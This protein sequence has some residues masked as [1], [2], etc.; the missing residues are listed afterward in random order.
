MTEFKQ[1]LSNLAKEIEDMLENEKLSAIVSYQTD[2]AQIMIEIHW[3]DW[4]HEHKRVDYLMA[5]KFKM[6]CQDTEVID[7]DDTDCYSAIHYYPYNT[8]NLDRLPDWCYGVLVPDNRII[9]IHKGM[10]GYY[11]T[12]YDSA[13]SFEA[14][15]EWCNKIN[16]QIGVSKEVRKAMEAG[17]MWGWDIP[18]INPDVW[19][20]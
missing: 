11:N 7:E 4:K 6:F 8:T 13:K 15:E 12:D 17:S 5:T 2:P 20:E 9:I 3:G 14:A 18:G 16:E 1:K 19:K 10:S